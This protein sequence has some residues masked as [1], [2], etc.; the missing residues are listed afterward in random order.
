MSCSHR[1]TVKTN[2]RHL[3]RAVALRASDSPSSTP[4]VCDDP[5]PAI[6]ALAVID[7][8]S[9]RSGALM[10]IVPVLVRAPLALRRASRLLIRDSRPHGHV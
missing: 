5:C 2:D 10:R 1:C 9:Q 7:C 3:S 4:R 6:A 8:G